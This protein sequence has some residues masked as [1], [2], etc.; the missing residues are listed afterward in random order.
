MLDM[1]SAAT[2]MV[3]N[4]VL[5][6]VIA[7]AIWRA[8]PSHL[9]GM[10]WIAI[11]YLMLPLSFGTYLLDTMPGNSPHLVTL[12]NLIGNMGLACIAEGIALFL[13]HHRMPRFVTATAVLTV[14]AFEAVQWLAPEAPQYRIVI[15]QMAVPLI[16]SRG[17]WAVSRSHGEK[18][19]RGL[20][21][22]SLYA[23]AALCG[24]RG[25]F[26]IFHPDGP[27]LAFAPDIMAW[28][29]FQIFVSHNVTFFAILVMVGAR[30]SADLE[31][32][33]EH[34]RRERQTNVT[35]ADALDRER[36]QTVDQRQFLTMLAHQLG[37]ALALIGRSAEMAGIALTG[38]RADL[39]AR[40]ETILSTAQKTSKL[41]RDLITA[42]QASLESFGQETLDAADIVHTAV[43]SLN[44]GSGAERILFTPANQPIACKGDR[45]MIVTAVINLLDNALKYSPAASEISVT[46]GRERE[47]MLLCVRDHGIGFPPEEIGQVGS[48]FFRASNAAAFPGTGLGLHIVRLI[49]EKHGGTLAI[50]NH[51]DGGANIEM[52]FPVTYIQRT[53]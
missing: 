27:A 30:L 14:A 42:E 10:G 51:K 33:S 2:F 45:V 5:D 41:I 35:L 9:R 48:R 15:G 17:I 50:S 26:T 25:L 1:T 46:I 7:L 8:R 11:G 16:F 43:A 31:A 29:F 40:L 39:S 3:S 20:L 6:G 32:Q 22:I 13:G 34:L 18:I 36:R 47:S 53:Q 38:N 52:A 24:A 19:A 49:L 28:S 23:V 37:S 21:S 12:R 44:H 4:A